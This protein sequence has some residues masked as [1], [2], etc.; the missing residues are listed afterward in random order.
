MSRG[1]ATHLRL[2]SSHRRHPRIASILK[3]AD[4]GV[5]V[6]IC[7]QAGIGVPPV[8]KRGVKK[9]WSE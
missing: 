9:E 7:R 3:Q 5:P 2:D 6:S 8:K 4:A 1:G